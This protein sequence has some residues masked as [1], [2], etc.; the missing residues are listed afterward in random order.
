[1]EL[2]WG[3][4]TSLAAVVK[5]WW[6]WWLGAV[7]SLGRPLGGRGEMS[8]TVQTWVYRMR[9]AR[10]ASNTLWAWW[11]HSGHELSLCWTGGQAGRDPAGVILQ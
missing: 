6:N 11:D 10:A 4:A 9:G 1:M 8:S 5:P 7:P 2:L 3:G